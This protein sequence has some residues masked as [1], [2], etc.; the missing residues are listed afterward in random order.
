M[1]EGLPGCCSPAASYVAAGSLP[2]LYHLA[3]W[4]GKPL[5]S[6]H[7]L[8]SLL[9]PALPLR[10]LH[11]SHETLP[12]LPLELPYTLALELPYTLPL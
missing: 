1:G 10:N 12:L 2:A 5:A 3:G 7:C 11:T 6:C 8:P 4:L 9:H